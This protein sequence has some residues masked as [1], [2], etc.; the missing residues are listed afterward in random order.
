MYTT[1][2]TLIQVFSGQ[3]LWAQKRLIYSVIMHLLEVMDIIDITSQIKTDNGPAYVSKK[4]K[5][6]FAYCTIKY[7]TGIPKSP[8]C[9]AVIERTNWTV[10]G[11]LNKQKGMENIPRHRLHSALLTLNFL[12]TNE[13]GTTTAERLDNRKILWIKSAGVFQECVYL[14]MET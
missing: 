2:L 1:P 14:T 11:M 3:L 8:T 7:I 13:K 10:K 5:H 9:Q 12:N 6:Y 4:M